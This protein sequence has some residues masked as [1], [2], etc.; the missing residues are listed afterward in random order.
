MSEKIQHALERIKNFLNLHVREPF[1]YFGW[2]DLLDIILL[3]VLL[4]SL[5]RF[6]KTRRAG[7]VVAGLFVVIVASLLVT[8]LHLPALSYIVR[9]FAS[10]FFFCFVL[11]FQPE[12]RDALERIGNSKVVAP[13]SDTIPTKLYPLAN[14][15]TSETLDAVFEM[16][17]TCTGALIVF[18]GMTKLGDY[19]GSGKY[20]DAR[21]TSHL[22]TNIFFDKAPLHDGA[23][24]IRDFRTPR[25]SAGFF[26]S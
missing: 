2:F 13:M 5:Y 17:E 9:L 7:R 6:A 19:I 16:S 15:V 4:Y 24:I 25:C 1:L 18:E 3:T 10:A 8:L 26:S 21:V 23:V 12:I 11:I 20:V 14:E 22:L